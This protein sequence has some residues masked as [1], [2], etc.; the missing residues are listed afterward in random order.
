MTFFD[1]FFNDPFFRE[2]MN[3]PYFRGA[4]AGL[5]GAPEAQTGGALTT[6]QP[7]SRLTAFRTPRMDVTET[8]KGYLINADLP[9][10]KKEDVHIHLQEDMLTIE[11]ERKEEN[12]EETATRHLVERSYGRFSRS[13]RLPNDANPNECSASM[14]HGVLQVTVGKREPAEAGRKRI[15]VA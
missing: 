7:S 13:F 3:D 15:S 1:R 2:A 11:G 4:S 12:V 9:G 10:L 5:L 14:E 8:D 6:Q